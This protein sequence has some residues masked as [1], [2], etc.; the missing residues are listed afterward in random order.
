MSDL[1]SRQAVELRIHE[2]L[3]NET[4]TEGMLRDDI[5]NLP[6]AQKKGE[7]VKGEYWTEGCGMG[8]TYGYYY[9]CSLCN[10]EIQGDYNKCRY[11]FCPNCGARMKGE[12]DENM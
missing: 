11:N 3:T 4:Y 9:N 6:S 7:W 5:H 1:I 12:T 10:E 8:E 2:F